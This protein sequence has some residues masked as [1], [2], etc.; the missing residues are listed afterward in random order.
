MENYYNITSF[1]TLQNLQLPVETAVATFLLATLSYLVILFCNLSLILTVVLNKTLHQPMYLLLINLPINDLLGSSAFYPQVIKELLLD[2]RRMNYAAC[3]AQAFC[4]H[5]YAVGAV[6]ILTVMAYDRYVAICCPLKY[7]SIMTHSHIMKLIVTIW[8]FNFMLVSVLFILLLRLPRCRS[9]ITHSYCDNPTLL[10]LVC[11]D[12]SVNNIYGLF[13]VAIVQV[14]SHAVI[15]YT[16]LRILLACFRGNRADARSKAMQTCATHLAVFLVMECMGLFTITY[17]NLCIQANPQW[18]QSFDFNQFEDNQ[19]PLQ[20]NQ[21]QLYT[22]VLDQGKGRLV[23][24]VTL[25]PCWGVSVGELSAAPLQQYDKRKTIAEKLSLMKSHTSLREVGFLQIKTLNPEWNKVFTFPIKDIHDVVELTVLDENGD[26]SPNVLGK[27][28]IPLLS[29]QNGQKICRLLKK[30]SLGRAAKGSITLE[31]E[32]IYN[33]VLAQNIYRVRKITTAV[34]YTLQ[35][36]KSCFQWESRQ[37]SLIAF[38]CHG[39]GGGGGGGGH[40]GP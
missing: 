16:Y 11:A 8:V 25:L 38:L 13:T 28:A 32:V 2:T 36:I 17:L 22:N 31:L 18:R 20:V 35:Y 15:V 27:V 21:R 1:L 6:L 12:K 4:V 14:I 7:N 10:R 30:E 29:V 39:R 9:L 37:R 40:L 23:F 33:P 19:E 3:I 26:K 24:L 5:T 34:L